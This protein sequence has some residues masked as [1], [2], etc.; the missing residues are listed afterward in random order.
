MKNILKRL[1]N[2]EILV[3]DGAMGTMLFQ[4]GL[5]QGEPPESVCLNKPVILEEIAKAYFEAGADIIETDTFG[6]SPLKLADYNMQDKTEEINRI[7]V[8]IVR[9][10]V[11]DK[12]YISGSV[13]PSGKKLKPFGDT[14]PDHIFESYKRQIKAL[15]KAE[16]DLLCIETMMD[17]NESLLAVKA[18][19]SLSSEIPIIATFTLNAASSGFYTMMGNDIPT[20]CLELEKAGANIIGSNCGNGIE[21]MIKIAKKFKENST[22]PIIIQS[23]AGLP[24]IKNN[25]LIY[26]ETSNFFAEKTKELIETGVSIIGGCC[27]TTPEYI[28][29]IRKTVDCYE[30][31]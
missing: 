26:S 13:G 8:E 25:E 2:S 5:K 27:G 22:L 7:A 29:A 9:K 18:A 21:N 28:R 24:E 6:G 31:I 20:L 4:R 16:V 14:E 12:A 19:R 1:N 23:N 3:G 10:A 15:I 30:S 11:S 17:L